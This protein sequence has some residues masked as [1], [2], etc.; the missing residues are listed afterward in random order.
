M[1]GY[2]T[3]LNIDKKR[4]RLSVRIIQNNSILFII[5][6]NL[7][8]GFLYASIEGV[9]G[10]SGYVGGHIAAYF[11]VLFRSDPSRVDYGPGRSASGQEENQGENKKKHQNK[12]ITKAQ[13]ALTNIPLS[14]GFVLNLS[15]PNSISI[16]R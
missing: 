15:C 1:A 14:R 7:Y 6:G 16:E 10:G 13:L 4:F 5:I 9:Y 2:T 12:F 11:K 3:A 8:L